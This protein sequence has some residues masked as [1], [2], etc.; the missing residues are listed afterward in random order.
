ME[1][2]VFQIFLVGAV[3][4]YF[5]TRQRDWKGVFVELSV[6]LI[7]G[8]VGFFLLFGNGAKLFFD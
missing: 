2:I 5:F 8:S 6:F 7:F 1:K 3:G 4:L